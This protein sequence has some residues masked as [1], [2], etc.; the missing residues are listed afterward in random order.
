MKPVFIPKVSNVMAWLG[1]FNAL[2]NRGASE[3]CL[4]LVDGEP[5]L[6]KTGTAVWWGVQNQAIHVRAKQGWTHSWCLRDIYAAATG[7]PSQTR[8]TAKLFEAVVAALT[9]RQAQAARVGHATT[10]LLIDEA[11]HAVAAGRDVVE[12]IR[13]ITDHLEIPTVLVGMDRIRKRLDRYPQVASRISQKVEF[14]PLTVDDVRAVIA[15]ISEV[16]VKDDLIAYTHRAS[17]GYIRELKEAVA[18]IE[19]FGLRQA[20]TAVGVE[21]MRGQVLLHSRETGAP[22]VVA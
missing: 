10:V 12:G 4:M 17:G 18:A 6:G 1:A 5:G 9:A 15:G 11:D 14:K 20:G 16:E 8:D 13:D 19:R 2:K 7:R 21:A 22:V 3:S